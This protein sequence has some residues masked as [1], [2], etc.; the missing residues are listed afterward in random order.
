MHFA[1]VGSDFVSLDMLRRWLKDFPRYLLWTITADLCTL[2]C[3]R[4]I[5]HCHCTEKIS[6]KC[7]ARLTFL[8]QLIASQ[9]KVVSMPYV[10]CCSR[11][12]ARVYSDTL[13]LICAARYEVYACMILD[14]CGL[15]YAK[16]F[17]SELSVIVLHISD[18]SSKYIVLAIH[19]KINLREP[20]RG[21][22]LGT[23]EGWRDND[24][25][26]YMGKF[27]ELRFIEIENVEIQERAVKHIKESEDSPHKCIQIPRP[28]KLP[29]GSIKCFYRL[30]WC[31]C[32]RR[33]NCK[34]KW[35]SII[36]NKD[37]VA[38]FIAD[39]DKKPSI[40]RDY[41]RKYLSEM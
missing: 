32:D 19:N 37:S 28:E 3:Q 21:F 23:W 16:F 33:C 17:C 29:D 38:Q 8:A 7:I 9:R 10:R 26:L 35:K 5:L 22:H 1:S 6:L 2:P 14:N 12:T 4:G 20:P 25:K 24:T 34:P 15:T 40:L 11:F 18:Y 31:L 39:D 36:L 41:V 13:V 30:E 27:C